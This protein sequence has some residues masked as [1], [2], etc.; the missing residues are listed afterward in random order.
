[1]ADEF[2]KSCESGSVPA[3]PKNTPP[4]PTDDL[5]D[6]IR[7]VAHPQQVTVV[8]TNKKEPVET[9]SHPRRRSDD[10]PPPRFLARLRAVGGNY[11]R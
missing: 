7:R 1:M 3:L 4:E 2:I 9:F 8:V 6:M 11:T 10:P 5:D